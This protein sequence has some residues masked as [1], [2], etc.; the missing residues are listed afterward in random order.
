MALIRRNK[1]K[2]Q[3]II[4]TVAWGPETKDRT[5][6]EFVFM[7]QSSNTMSAGTMRCLDK[8][9]PDLHS[10][11]LEL[12]RAAKQIFSLDSFVV[13]KFHTLVS[14]SA[15]INKVAEAERALIAEADGYE[16]SYLPDTQPAELSENDK[17]AVKSWTQWIHA[18]EYELLPL[19]DIA[20]EMNAKVSTTKRPLEL[21]STPTKRVAL[22]DAEEPE[23]T[24]KD[25]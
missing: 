19:A 20:K 1:S 6:V 4:D 15:A 3:T 18:I 24:D 5:F 8:H 10:R 23:K 21:D 22:D 9:I 12:E 14:L 11:F 7:R 25:A 17:R 13:R 2:F 16:W